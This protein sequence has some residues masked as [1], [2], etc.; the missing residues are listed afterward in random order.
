MYIHLLHILSWLNKVFI[1]TGHWIFILRLQL[2]IDRT[3][4]EEY[5]GSY[6]FIFTMVL[7]QVLSQSNTMVLFLHKFMPLLLLILNYVQ[8]IVMIDVR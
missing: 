2:K 1:N 5:F 6:I 4:F 3:Y 7:L 8:I